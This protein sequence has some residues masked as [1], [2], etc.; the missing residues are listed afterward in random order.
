MLASDDPTEIQ[1][2]AESMGEL[3]KGNN[4]IT[5]PWWAVGASVDALFQIAAD[6]EHPLNAAAVIGAQ[7]IATVYNEKMGRKK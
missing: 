3:L 4:P 5:S 6:T 1:R 7:I 2:I